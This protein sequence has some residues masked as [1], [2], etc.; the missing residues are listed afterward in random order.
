MPFAALEVQRT[1]AS[2]VV[3]AAFGL[4]QLSLYENGH[5]YQAGHRL[6]TGVSASSS[7]GLRAFTFG[8]TTEL[9]TETGE[10][11]QGVVNTEEGN[12][13]R[14]DLYVGGSV[15]WRPLADLAIA[16]DLK[17][18]VYSY[19]NGSQLD[20]TAILA[21]GLVKTFDLAPKA[22]WRG[23]DHAS[24]GPAGSAPDL[25]AVPGRITVFDLWAPWCAPCRALDTDLEA[26]ARRYPD[27]L[28]VR[29]LD[30]VDPESAAWK[31][32]LL[33]GSFELPHLKVVREDGSVVFE[34]TA[35]VDE[36]IRAL[37]AVL[38]GTAQVLR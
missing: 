8:V 9:H 37:E 25:V 35:P 27:R 21:V 30:V 31:R 2:V 28:A 29:K 14:G 36:L 13:G 24:V 16:A 26:L 5:G 7:L 23:L 17:V 4:A 20:Y 3:L 1:V 38:Q 34:R 11:W 19:V 12:A 10:R 15:A 18:P 32:Y 22:T 6:S 33:P